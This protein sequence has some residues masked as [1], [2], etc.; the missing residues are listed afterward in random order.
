MMV[1]VC[2]AKDVTFHL[3]ALSALRMRVRDF[4]GVA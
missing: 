4:D 3:V 1:I 2:D